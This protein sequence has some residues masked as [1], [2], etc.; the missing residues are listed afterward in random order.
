M[1]K[2]FLTLILGFATLTSFAQKYSE[3]VYLKNGSMI[4]GT[5]IEEIPNKSLKLETRDGSIFVYQ[6]DEVE[7]IT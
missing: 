1:K 6:M 7:K 2:I 3:T 5:I 4:K